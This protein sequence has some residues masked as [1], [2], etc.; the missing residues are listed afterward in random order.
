VRRAAQLAKLNGAVGF[1]IDQRLFLDHVYAGADPTGRVR[2][3]YQPGYDA[4]R[5]YW[6]FYRYGLGLEKIDSE[7][8][9]LLSDP[10]AGRYRRVEFD[11]V[12]TLRRQ[13]GAGVDR[14]C[15][16]PAKQASRLFLATPNAR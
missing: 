3:T 16:L 2:V 13:A 5:R 14:R 10:H 7:P 12:V 4:W 6:R 11:L 1:S 8:T 15:Q 9:W